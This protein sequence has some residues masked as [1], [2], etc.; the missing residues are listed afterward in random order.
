MT[1][2]ID[3]RAAPSDTI[4]LISNLNMKRRRFITDVVAGVGLV[5]GISGQSPPGARETISSTEVKRVL[6]M[7]KCHFDCGF[8]DTQ[9]GVMRKYF[10]QYFP[11]AIAVAQSRRA[12]GQERYVWTTGSWLLY[13]YLEQADTSARNHMEQAIV[14]G[15]IAWHALPFSWQTELLE[16]S[17]I[18]GTIG[19]SKALD[20][21]FGRITTGAKMTDV[22]GHSRGLIGPLAGAG[23]KFLDI[24][25]NSAS[26]PPDVP[27]LFV[28]KSA[29]A[30]TLTVMYHRKDYGGV[31]VVPGSDLAIAIEVRNDNSGPHT[32]EEI[33]EIYAKL[34]QQFP[35]ATVTASNLTDIANAVNAFRDH[36][37]VFDDEIGDTWIYGVPSDPV[38][39]ARYRELVRLRR[40]WIDKGTIHA[41]GSTDIA[42]LRRFSLAA[43]HTWGTDTK[44]WLDFDHYT[45]HDL[46]AMLS[47]PN[48]KTVIASWTE[49]R[50]DI[51]EGIN[52][53]PAPLRAEAQNRLAELK[54]EEP[55]RNGFTR[56]NP[57]AVI[58][59]RHFI[60]SL[61]PSTGAFHRF[62]NR[63]SGRNW[64]SPQHPLALLSYQTMSKDDYARFLASY[65][66][67]QT[68]WAP[69]DFGKPNI[70]HFGARSNLWTP[71][72]IAGWVRENDQGQ[73]VL[74]ELQFDDSSALQ[75]GVVA[76]P[77]KT[78]LQCTFPHAAPLVHM[79][80]QW[81]R[82]KSN[83]LPEALWLTFQPDA[84]VTRN[85]TLSKVD[86]P[87]SPFRV[88]SGGNRHMHALSSGLTYEDDAGMFQIQPLD[89]PVVALGERSPVFFSNSQP[90]FARGIH[91]S[92]YNNGWG[93]N[94]IQ[95]FGE[96]MRFR[97]TLNA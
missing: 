44:T 20:R 5:Y 88:V 86:Q 97:F 38:K 91:F 11:A 39:V 16:P 74:A 62:Q 61:D 15:D 33:K 80:L 63:K 72:L 12:A 96:D 3:H 89:A 24:G 34:K 68:D 2:M 19:F 6:V 21:R 59:T 75:S 54:P 4:P 87:I 78:Y 46:A 73:Q 7:F 45:P 81:F 57:G 67:V 37:P 49:K 51:D 25:V 32:P 18:T 52:A 70:E 13:E 66:T 1:A 50:N 35:N 8:I 47:Q 92:L 65:I 93:T 23:V 95:W 26:T 31:V 55:S 36:F 43:E 22:P 69:K 60:V 10:K 84:R 58:E 27:P 42:F 41:G 94:Y 64:S 53:L 28:W 85:W 30:D 76:W 29:T 56:H 77:E 83:R 14:V 82:K 90:D 9:A 79:S 48:Y 40:E 17:L 71:K